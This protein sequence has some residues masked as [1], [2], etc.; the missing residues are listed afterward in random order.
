MAEP[1]TSTTT[2]TIVTITVFII[3]NALTVAAAPL[4]A[5]D[6]NIKIFLKEEKVDVRS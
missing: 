5:A 1:F 2:T 6:T 4:T 3:A